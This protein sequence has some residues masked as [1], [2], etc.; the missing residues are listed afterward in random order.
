[1][2]TFTL[3]NE[4]LE[5]VSNYKYLGIII[6]KNGKFSKAISERMSKANRATHMIKQIIGYSNNISS[7]LAMS[8]FDKQISPILL[9]G[10]PIWGIPDNNRH[11]QLNILLIDTQVKKQVQKLINE[12]IHRQVHLDEVRVCRDCSNKVA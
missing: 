3:N 9:Y 4:I 1:M 2:T 7:K 12:R 11:I 8:L 10:S 6:H 5:N